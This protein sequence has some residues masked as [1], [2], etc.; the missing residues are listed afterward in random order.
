MTISTAG[1]LAPL[2]RINGEVPVVDVQTGKLTE[3]GVQVFNGW[4]NHI[5]G[6]NRIIPCNASGQNVITLT[7]LAASPLIDKYND[8]EVFAFVGVDTSTGSVTATVVPRK[9]ALATLKVYTSPGLAQAGSG[10]VDSSGL[11]L[12]VY[13]DALD[14]GAGGFVLK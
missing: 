10:D 3:Y 14:G 1:T 4:Y 6:S 9:G 11:Y 7:P 13:N 5:N 8:Y 12:L 2:S